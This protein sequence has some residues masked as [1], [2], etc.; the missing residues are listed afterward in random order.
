ME[1]VWFIYPYYPELPREWPEEYVRKKTCIKTPERA[2]LVHIYELYM[3]QYLTDN[4]TAYIA[5]TL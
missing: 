5:I 3:M 1:L 2:D 4:H